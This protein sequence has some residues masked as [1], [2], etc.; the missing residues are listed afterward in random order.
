[1][2][3]RQGQWSWQPGHA[4]VFVGSSGAGPVT[5]TCCPVINFFT[6]TNTD[7]ARTYQHDHA[8]E[9][10]VPSMPDAAE[11]GAAVFGGLLAEPAAGDLGGGDR[12]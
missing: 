12:W 2:I 4:V 7:N 1:M 9:G 3:A 8:L 5:D 10:V 6:N 11:A